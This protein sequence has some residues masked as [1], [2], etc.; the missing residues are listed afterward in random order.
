MNTVRVERPTTR[1]IKVGAR[2][3]LRRAPIWLAALC[4]A[5]ACSFAIGRATD[6]GSAPHAEAPSSPPVAHVSA[7]IPIQ[8][9]E[10]PPIATSTPAPAPTRASAP[11]TPAPAARAPAQSSASEAPVSQPAPEPVPEPVRSAAPPVSERP[12]SGGGSSRGAGAGS[13]SGGG[14]H[15]SPAAG[16]GTFESSG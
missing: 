13:S 7:A 6:P 8:L 2:L 14:G 15:S 4:V 1:T 9:T 16:G 12:S 5:F 10:A 3:G 11:A